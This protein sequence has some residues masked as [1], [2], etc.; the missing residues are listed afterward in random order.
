MVLADAEIETLGAGVGGSG[1]GGG[2]TTGSSTTSPLLLH[3]PSASVTSNSADVAGAE[4]IFLYENIILNRFSVHD[5]SRSV[6]SKRAAGSDEGRFS[7]LNVGYP[8]GYRKLLLA[9]PL[10]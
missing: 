8:G 9:T 1:G 6:Y 3:P 2:V 5:A 4:I 10:S 7:L